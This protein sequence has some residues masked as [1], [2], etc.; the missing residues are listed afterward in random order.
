MDTLGV[1]MAA[2]DITP[3]IHPRC[4]AWGCNPAITTVD[5][6]LAGRALA[7]E[8]A[9]RRV[10]WLSLDLVGDSPRLTLELRR[11]VA[12]AIG[13]APEHLLWGTVQNHACGAAPW[14]QFSG[15]TIADHATNDPRFMADQ[16]QRFTHACI[17]A[18][19]AALASVQP[20]RVYAGNGYCDSVSFNTRVFL[21]DGQVAYC[22]HHAE[23]RHF[24]RPIDP[25]I[26]LVRFDDPAG[27][28]IG[29][30]FNYNMHAATLINDTRISPDWIG[31][32]RGIIEAALGG[33]P[34]LYSQGFCSDVN[35]YH[36]FG[37]P[38]QARDTGARL[39]AAA[40]EALARLIPAR[41]VPLRL[42]HKTIQLRCQPM[43][44]RP[45]FEQ[46]IAELEQF[47]ADLR[48]DPLLRFGCGM[49]LPEAFSGEERA[50][51]LDYRLA[52][53]REGIRLLETAP[54]APP[55]AP[56][57]AGALDF[58]FA[59]LRIGDVGALLSPG[60]CF[61]ETGLTLRRRSPFVHTLICGDVNGLF[62][63]IFTDAEIDGNGC[64]IDSYYEIMALDGFRL[65]P[66]QGT[67][68]QFLSEATA[69]LESLL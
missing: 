28:P 35:C 31:T 46:R 16:R 61:A 29:A 52:Y 17:D 11:E 36:L 39:G 59:A 14:S 66:A 49:N 9:G 12:D 33:A 7:L 37:T 6:P 67:E 10:V 5:Q 45:Q 63:N 41:S 13:L 62:G 19:G 44:S 55:G 18:A 3:G 30:I 32:T 47:A 1:G 65:P 38:R 25:T 51:I 20:A 26:G 2:F 22:R 69:L 48:R 54:G 4:G 24:K 40:V 42:A 23:A 64:G 21:P 43:P 53:L 58:T 8:Q 60:E 68:A 27:K 15:T 34:A 50:A 57:G 56:P